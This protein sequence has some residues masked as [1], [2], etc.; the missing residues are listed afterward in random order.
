MYFRYGVYVRTRALPP[1]H[2]NTCA[3][4]FNVCCT[5]RTVCVC[6][7]TV[8][9]HMAG[10]CTLWQVK[11]DLDIKFGMSTLA[12]NVVVA[13]FLVQEGAKVHIKNKVGLHPLRPC[14]QDVAELIISYA[15]DLTFDRL[16]Q[17]LP[18]AIPVHS[19]CV[20]VCVRAYVRT[21]IRA[22][23]HTCMLACMCVHA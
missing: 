6:I 18:H 17:Q 22:Y 14:P 7:R 3:T 5:L 8:H 2:A 9:N 21:C 20:C 12:T 15:A 13:I 11:Q 1:L 10:L 4:Y 23:M 19:V 16:A